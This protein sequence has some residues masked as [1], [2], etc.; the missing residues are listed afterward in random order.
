MAS[1]ATYPDGR[2]WHIILF[3]DPS[4]PGYTDIAEED[5]FAD[6]PEYSASVRYPGPLTLADL[7]ASVLH[8]QNAGH[9]LLILCNASHCFPQH[10]TAAYLEAGIAA[11][12]Q[13]HADILLGAVNWMDSAIQ[14]DQHLFWLD[15][16]RGLRFVVLFR[17]FYDTLL[18]IGED[19]DS[20]IT[21]QLLGRIAATK[22]LLYPFVSNVSEK[23]P[24]QHPLPGSA[25]FYT[26]PA[27]QL[28]LLQQVKKYYSSIQTGY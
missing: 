11:A 17:R 2:K 3:T 8:A 12:E 4:E 15:G 27:E 18:H 10:Y 5:P 13:H 26:D 7:Q 28:A 16:F 6:K 14:I 9:D 22:L 19:R 1:A 20:I 23:I 24:K 21:D 25:P